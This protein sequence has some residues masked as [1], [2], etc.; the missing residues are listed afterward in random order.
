M[1]DSSARGSRSDLRRALE[2]LAWGRGVQR[3]CPDL[4]EALEGELKELQHCWG[5]NLK[6]H[7]NDNLERNHQVVKEAILSNLRVHIRN[8]K[9]PPRVPARK[10]RH[11]VAVCFNIWDDEE[12]AIPAEL[13]LTERREWLQVS[14][15]KEF[16]VHE[17][18]CRRYF[19]D[20]IIQIEQQ[21]R[22]AGYRPVEVLGPDPGQDDTS[23]ENSSAIDNRISTLTQNIS[24][25][26]RSDVQPSPAPTL[27]EPP[28]QT[29]F[30]GTLPHISAT[31]P[32]GSKE[33]VHSSEDEQPS[34]SW[35]KEWDIEADRKSRWLRFR[36]YSTY[37]WRFRMA[38]WS[39]R[40]WQRNRSMR[41]ASA[42]SNRVVAQIDQTLRTNPGLV[43]LARNPDANA[44]LAF[45]GGKTAYMRVA[46]RE[47]FVAEDGGYDSARGDRAVSVARSFLGTRGR[48]NAA[49]ALK[50]LAQNQSQAV[51]PGRIDI[52]WIGMERTTRGNVFLIRALADMFQQLS[53]ANGRADLGGNWMDDDVQQTALDCQVLEAARPNSTE[54]TQALAYNQTVTDLSLMDAIG[55]IGVVKLVQGHVHQTTQLVGNVDTDEQG[56]LERML[57][58]ANEQHRYQAALRALE[59]H[60]AIRHADANSQRLITDFFKR[61][62]LEQADSDLADWLAMRARLT[63]MSGA[64]LKARARIHEA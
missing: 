61:I 33:V 28:E 59:M 15:K 2:R 23:E 31:E 64:Q 57:D 21:I 56:T 29:N 34:N 58:S 27:F 38:S 13:D 48:A 54:A 5:L 45:S 35:P 63:G 14:A 52:V 9:V 55:R 62:G 3:Q 10:Y 16:R 51:G 37:L 4:F 18:T 50:I 19:D 44:V 11:A 22:A 1:D 39:V 42:R 17:R 49:A 47:L 26:V 46:A 32:E 8:L 7:Q 20:A 25:V 40:R 53:R 43:Q 36:W 24:F 60:H 41:R 6:R 12:Y 30:A